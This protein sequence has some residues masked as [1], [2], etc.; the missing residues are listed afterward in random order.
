MTQQV[1]QTQKVTLPAHVCTK[2]DEWLLRYPPEQRRSGVFEALRLMQLENN[3]YL[4]T[5]IL[6]AVADYLGIPKISVYE[7]AT[8]FTMFRLTPHGK[9]VIELCTNVSCMLNGAEEM[10]AYLKEKLGVDLNDVT[11][12]GLFTIKE[13]ECLGAC[14]GAPA[15]QIGDQYHE[16]LTRDK[17]DQLILAM[18]GSAS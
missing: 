2:I 8:F 13:V 7:V 17:L 14:V 9:H 15:C 5:P 1:E 12:D 10:L 18:R 6:D 3:G 16:N 4:T 11:A